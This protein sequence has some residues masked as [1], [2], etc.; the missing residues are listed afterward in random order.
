MD[1]Y[2]LVNNPLKKFD[3]KNLHS[4]NVSGSE[5]GSS[6]NSNVTCHNCGKKGHIQKDF[7]SMGNRSSGNPPNNYTND[8]PEWVTK[9]P[10]V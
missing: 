2:Q 5:G 6:V 8:I 9:K 3:F 7:W 1:I 10:V 4:G